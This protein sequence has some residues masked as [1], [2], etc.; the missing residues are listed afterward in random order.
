MRQVALIILLL[1]A[2][3]GFGQ[4]SAKHRFGPEDW[5]ALRVARAVAVAPDGNWILYEVNHGAD[6]GPEQSEWWMIHRDGT[7][8]H[9]VDLPKDFSPSG[10]ALEGDSLYGT[11]HI[12]GKSQFA[13]FGLHGITEQSVPSVTV[14]L[15][16][17][18]GTAAPSPDGSEFA[19]TFDP[20]PP[21]PRDDVRTVEEPEQTGIYVVSAD[22]AKGARW[23]DSLNHVSITAWSPDGRSLAVLSST[24]KIGFHTVTSFIDV[25]NREGSSRVAERPTA[26]GSITWIDDGKDL[27]FLSTFTHVLTPDH[28][29]TVPAAG[30]EA[31]DRSPT[32]EGSAIQMTSDPQGRVWVSVERGARREV[33]SFVDGVLTP[34]YKWAAGNVALPIFAP[35]ATRADSLVFTVDDPK[36][37]P[38]L[39]TVESGSLKR[40]TDE[41][42]DDLDATSLADVRLVSWISKQG[43]A[44]EGIATFPV[45]FEPTRQYPFMV[46][47]HG[48]PE[49]NDTLKLDPLAQVFAAEG[50][51]VLQPEYRG[52][53]GYGSAFMEAIYQHRGDR[54]FQD[55]D[56]ATD[57]AVAQGWADP[58]RLC[59]FGWSAGGYITAWTLT[60]T[61]RYRAAIEGAGVTDWSSFIWTSDSVQTDYDG[62]WPDENPE[63]FRRFSPVVYAKDITT[64]L[65]ILHGTRDERIP[66]YQGLELFQILAARGKTARMVTYP[67]S[68][69]FPVLWQ[70][71]LDVLREISNW[72]TQHNS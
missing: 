12:G 42:Q 40:I 10:F 59:I 70:Q 52:S 35:Y 69:H 39:A 43:I 63:A 65:L 26:V 57:F 60:Q 15:P 30:G 51:V 48:G 18:V 72:L 56:S 32:L 19:L 44:L 50:Y 4:T 67:G 47:P 9:R 55:V 37:A 62:R 7:G 53:I 41:S 27:A 36:H 6:Q 16:R 29:W 1:C 25:C 31:V 24:P 17:G 28:V 5:A 34:A 49:D 58:K 61:H 13:V 11:W 38:N 45:G 21:D 23:C 14:L 64:P 20:R 8:R 22:G 54:A 3:A 46:F 2:I 68:P 71:R 33:D 66:M